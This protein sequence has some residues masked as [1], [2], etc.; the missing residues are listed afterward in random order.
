V[1]AIELARQAYA[2][3]TIP[4]KSERSIEAQVIGKITARLRFAAVHRKSDFP[5]FVEAL[6]ENRKL[7]NA[8]AVDVADAGNDLPPPLR[9]QIFY[10]AEF[11]EIQSAKV[12]RGEASA[13]ALIE[14]N[15][16][17]MRGL[18]MGQDK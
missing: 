7:W 13:D 1:N 18:N 2:P 15:T 5:A 11:T 9:A 4:L 14:I 10:L 8:L 17:V 6:S 16:S 3:T 12:L